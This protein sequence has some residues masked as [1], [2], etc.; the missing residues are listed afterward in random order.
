[1]NRGFLMYWVEFVTTDPMV[2]FVREAMEKAGCPVS[3]TFFKP[4]ECTMNVGG[5]FKQDDGVRSS[6]S[7]SQPYFSR[8]FVRNSSMSAATYLHLSIEKIC[9]LYVNHHLV[10]TS[11]IWNCSNINSPEMNSLKGYHW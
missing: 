8:N 3:D 11:M 5:G 6:L 1:M 4:E 7:L 9:F 10:K 2:K